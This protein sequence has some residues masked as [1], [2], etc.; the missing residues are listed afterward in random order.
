MYMYIIIYYSSSN[1]IFVIQVGSSEETA[2]NIKKR[3]G[4]NEIQR[5]AIQNMIEEFEMSLKL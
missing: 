4:L 1:T 3:Y 5:D 2:S